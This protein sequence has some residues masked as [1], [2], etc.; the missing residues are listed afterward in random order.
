MIAIHQN[1]VKYVQES[2]KKDIKRHYKNAIKNLNKLK[3]EF[4]Y[5]QEIDYLQKVIDLF[6]DNEDILVW[7]L[8]KLDSEKDNLP[9]IPYIS[10]TPSK[11]KG[12]K[13]NIGTLIIEKLGYT[14]KRKSFYPKYFKEIGIRA[15]VYC[16][17]QHTIIIEKTSKS[18]DYSAKFEVDHYHSKSEYPFLSIC[19]FNLY[20]ACS[21]CN[22]VKSNNPIEFNLYTNDAIKTTKSDYKFKLSPYS[23]AKYLVTKDS[24]DIEVNFEEPNYSKPNM[25][26]FNDVFHIESIY[27]TQTDLIEEIIIKNQIYNKSYLQTLKYNFDK[28]SLQPELFKRTIV[29]NYIKDKDLHKRPMSKL[30]MDIAK[31]LGLIKND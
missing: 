8:D 5:Q 30:V 26:T 9:N 1:K 6:T 27:Q 3:G 11:P 21:S 15:C 23:K 4:K 2:F 31:D 24:N 7:P 14:S 12:I 29:G 10:I 20:P 28:L 19:L 22:G 16:N 13:S 25:R 17:S 18:N